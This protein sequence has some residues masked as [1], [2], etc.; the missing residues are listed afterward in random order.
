MSSPECS[1]RLSRV[2]WIGTPFRSKKLC[3]DLEILQDFRARP[4]GGV[5]KSCLVVLLAVVLLPALLLGGC[6]RPM[7][8]T[9]ASGGPGLADKLAAVEVT[10]IEIGSR[11]ARVAQQVRNNLQFAF[12]GGGE[13][14]APQYV[15]TLKVKSTD[16][17]FIVDATTNERQV[18]A[19]VVSGEFWLTPVGS[20]TP[21][22]AAKNYAR[23]AYDRSRQAYAAVRAARDAENGAAAVL[24]D[25]IKTRVAIYLAR[26]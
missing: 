17:D 18:D 11:D 10:P 16:S 26:P 24:A 6:F 4:L 15:L 25:A 13:A 20:K 19:V 14:A 5:R 12:T 22:L 2:S 7:Y 8:A 3:L 1:G 9:P 21:V 23:K